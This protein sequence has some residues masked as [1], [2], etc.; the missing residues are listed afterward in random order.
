MASTQ[1][2]TVQVSSLFHIPC[3]ILNGCWMLQSKQQDD[4]D[5][6][7]GGDDDDDVDDGDDR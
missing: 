4:D 2:T 3:Q 6:D 7:D 1:T 5:D